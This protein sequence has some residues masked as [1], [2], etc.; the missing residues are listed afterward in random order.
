MK[1]VRFLLSVVIVLFVFSNTQAQE[2]KTIESKAQKVE[3]TRGDDPNIIVPKALN[4]E[5]PVLK[6]K[7]EKTR[8]GYCKVFIDNNTGYTIDIYIDGAY[9]GTIPPWETQYTWAI[10]GKTK[11]YA[12]TIGGTYYWGPKYYDCNFEF[13]WRLNKY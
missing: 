2:K 7:E 10:S 12:K 4:D 6:P 9:K 1:K 5:N 11:F 13:T 3:S 8:A